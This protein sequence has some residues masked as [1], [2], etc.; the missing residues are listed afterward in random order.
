MKLEHVLMAAGALVL[1]LRKKNQ[2]INTVMPDTSLPGAST[3][4]P[5]PPPLPDLPLPPVDL[6]PMYTPMTPVAYVQEQASPVAQV[7]EPTP[8]AAPA[9][10]T[11]PQVISLSPP[12][13]SPQVSFTLPPQ[14]PYRTMPYRPSAMDSGSSR[15][16]P[17]ISRL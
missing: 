13:A 1:F 4:A 16:G 9:P 5:E 8:E 6:A 11:A 3:L 2:Q 7:V 17:R 10:Q 14:K 12:Q 15:R